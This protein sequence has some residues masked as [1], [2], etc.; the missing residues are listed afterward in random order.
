MKDDKSLAIRSGQP[1]GHTKSQMVVAL[2]TCLGLFYGNGQSS[3][4]VSKNF[5]IS[6]KNMYSCLYCLPTK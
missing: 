4:R 1:Q 5:D 2:Y 3:K 6:R